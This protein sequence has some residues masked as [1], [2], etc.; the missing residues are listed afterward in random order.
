MVLS[1]TYCDLETKK[2]N[3]HKITIGGPTSPTC[4]STGHYEGT[5]PCSNVVVIQ[6]VAQ[7]LNCGSVNYPDY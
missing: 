7:N 6:K 4:T 3:T 1:M 2:E 5:I